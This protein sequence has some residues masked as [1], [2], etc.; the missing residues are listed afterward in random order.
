MQEQQEQQSSDIHSAIIHPVIIV[1]G[2]L[3][4][5]LCALL[6]AEA[7]VEVLLLDAASC[8]DARRL[9]TRDARVFALNPA[10]MAL[11]QRVGVWDKIIR[12][13]PYQGMQVWTRDGR[14]QLEFGQIDSPHAA[15]L[16]E[17]PFTQQPQ[18]LGSMVE[19]SVLALAMQQQLAESRVQVQYGAKVVHLDRYPQ[20]W[21]VDL[22]DGRSLH[23]ALLIGADG[24]Q[25]RVRQAAGIAL[26]TLD[27]QQSALTC[28]IRSERPHAGV[29]RQVFLPNGPLALL[30]MADLVPPP[31]G[32][33]LGGGESTTGERSEGGGSSDAGHWQS[34]VWTMR[35][36]DAELLYQADDATL[37]LEIAQASEYALGNVT[38]VQSRGFFPLKAQQASHDIGERLALIGDA[39]HVIHPMAGQGVNL[40]VQDA[41]VLADCL[42]HD[43]ARGLWAH[44][45]TLQ[46]YA[47][48]RR[49]PNSLMMHGLSALGWLQGDRHPAWTWLRG[50][51]THLLAQ[52]PLLREQLTRQASGQQAL[53]NTRYAG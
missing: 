28:A 9:D 39:A 43:R 42:L 7:G 44:R 32:G 17:Q 45:Q 37:C 49:L 33:G 3:V 48:L 15:F 40:G 26:K 13:A 16:P 8:I 6:L 36:D 41:A 25:S 29:A 52:S 46:R 22:A 12:H 18:Q 50:E 2:G 34:I 24:A 1:G 10:S 20:A 21:R 4:G 38:S 27:Y 14:S 53:H 5:G 23:A 51:G 47:H 35:P 11:L 30:P 19:P 31:T